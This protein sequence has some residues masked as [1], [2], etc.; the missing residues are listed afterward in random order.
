MTPA[1]DDVAGVIAAILQTPA[2]SR[3]II[4]LTSGPVPIP[5]AIASLV[6]A[7]RP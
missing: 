5:E 2:V 3:E 1:R 4:E 7:P 6:R